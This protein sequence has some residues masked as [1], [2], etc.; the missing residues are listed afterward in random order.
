MRL[1]KFI[2]FGGLG[3][4]Y[5][6]SPTITNL[7]LN[8]RLK[9]MALEM[10]YT[11]SVFIPLMFPV[12]VFSVMTDRVEVGQPYPTDL[13][14]KDILV[15]LFASPIYI[16]LFNKDFFQGQSII[17]RLLGYQVVDNKTMSPASGLKCMLRNV[18]AP[19]WMIEGIVVLINPQRRIGD[20]IAGTK[21]IEVQTSD[22]QLILDEIK[23]VK[24]NAKTL[25]TLGATFIVM[26]FY[27]V[28]FDDKF[29]FW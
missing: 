22:P 29:R 11:L 16:A 10:V 13:Q 6:T 26:L 25:T 9:A 28:L 21:L 27:A 2:L 19:I 1:L 5:V 17:N 12:F 4:Y 8:K 24:L 23:Q 7:Q 20:F 14:S 3:K 15:M 18:T